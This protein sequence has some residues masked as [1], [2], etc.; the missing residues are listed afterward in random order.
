MSSDLR[1]LL[2]TSLSQKYLMQVSN[3][4]LGLSVVTVCS[5]IL[6]VLRMTEDFDL[7][8]TLGIVFFLVTTLQMIGTI[9]LFTY[10]IKIKKGFE[11]K[12]E[13]RIDAAF[14]GLMIYFLYIVVSFAFLLVIPILGIMINGVL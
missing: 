7:H 5:M 10:S 6:S 9:G 11:T 1:K 12:D 13:K 14:R 4:G 2:F 8:A 3:L